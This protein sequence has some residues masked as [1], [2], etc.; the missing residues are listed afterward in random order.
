[1]SY[2]RCLFS[3]SYGIWRA[4]HE[5]RRAVLYNSTTER[6]RDCFLAQASLPIASLDWAA[7]VIRSAHCLRASCEITVPERLW[8]LRITLCQSGLKRACCELALRRMHGVHAVRVGRPA[9]P[10]YLAAAIISATGERPMRPQ[11]VQPTSHSV[12]RASIERE[13]VALHSRMIRKAV[14]VRTQLPSRPISQHP[15][16][17]LRRQS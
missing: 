8:L 2:P 1:M 6:P 3:V 17:P 9:P 5:W 7:H 16:P 12:S 10:T 11:S 4:R 13:V 14:R 15:R